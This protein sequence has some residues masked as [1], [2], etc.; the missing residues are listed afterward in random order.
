MATP[1]QVDMT[2]LDNMTP[3][4]KAPPDA[5]Y[6]VLY[7]CMYTKHKTQKRKTWQDGFVALYASRRLVLYAEDEGKA[8]KAIDDAKVAPFDWDRKDEEH[9]E[10][11]K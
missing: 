6:N 11:S 9:F 4:S 5:R 1:A 10:T 3:I 2:Q 7:E 8:G